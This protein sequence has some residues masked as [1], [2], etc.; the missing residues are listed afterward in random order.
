MKSSRLMD[1][2]EESIGLNAGIMLLK[3][4]L[5]AENS[6]VSRELAERMTQAVRNRIDRRL[7]QENAR[8]R[9]LYDDPYYDKDKSP[10]Y[11]KS[12]I[13]GVADKLLMLYEAKKDYSEA[14]LEGI[15]YAQNMSN[16][17]KGQGKYAS[18]DRYQADT[19]WKWFYDNAAK[20][21]SR[22]FMDIP[23]YD[24][25]TSFQVLA[26]S[27]NESALRISG[28]N[29]YQLRLDIFSAQG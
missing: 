29:A 16:S 28:S 23:G 20:F 11:D 27:W 12:A 1:G 19:Y 24:K 14:I 2:N 10:I 5:F 22:Y 3:T 15:K 7:D 9:S 25:R 21:Q 6:Q 17:K 18:I 13:Y 8:I 26:D 4:N